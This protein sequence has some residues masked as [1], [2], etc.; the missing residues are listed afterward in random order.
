MIK[1]TVQ[2]F[3]EHAPS[4]YVQQNPEIYGFVVQDE[5]VCACCAARI[6]ARGCWQWKGVPLWNKDH[7][8]PREC[9]GCA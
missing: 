8:Q 1:E 2:R 9:V 6:M 4:G 3:L 5:F 7:P